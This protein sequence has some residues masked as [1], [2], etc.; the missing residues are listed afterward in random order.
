[1]SCALIRFSGDTKFG[2]PAD[3]LKS[4][5]GLSEKDLGRLNEWASG[6]L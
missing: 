2:N 5:K 3:M 4:R 6:N 1:M